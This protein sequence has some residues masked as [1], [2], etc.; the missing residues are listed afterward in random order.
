MWSQHGFWN[1]LEAGGG[2][3]PGYY[4]G[5]EQPYGYDTHGYHHIGDY[6]DD[7]KAKL[8]LSIQT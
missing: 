2:G 7:N 5:Y 6:Y 1:N 4:P 8:D 3:Y